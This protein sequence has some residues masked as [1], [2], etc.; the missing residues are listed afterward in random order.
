M[1]EAYQLM[2]DEL[3]STMLEVGL[4]PA[5]DPQHCGHMIRVVMDRNPKWYRELCERYP[6]TRKGKVRTKIKRGCTLRV[7]GRLARGEPVSSEYAG[8]F[9]VIARKICEDYEKDENCPF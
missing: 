7:L 9:K 1:K 8:D 2:Y 6:S 5:P 4:A 3:D